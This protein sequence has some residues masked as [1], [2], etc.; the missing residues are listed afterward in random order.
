MA[1]APD[2]RIAWRQ[3]LGLS[4]TNRKHFVTAP[5]VMAEG[6]VFAMDGQAHVSAHDAIT[7]RKLWEV[8][9]RPKGKDDRRDRDA[10]GGGLAYANGKV[11]VT[12]GYRLIAGLDA[13]SGRE[14]WVRAPT[15]P[16]TVRPTCRTAASSPSP[17]TTS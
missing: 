13:N 1:A 12:S 15:R 16:C 9:V 8:D 3:G 7:G 17:S 2:L 10:Y 14:V 5:P 11:F 6:K 4:G